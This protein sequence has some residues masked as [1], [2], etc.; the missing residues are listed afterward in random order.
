LETY[1]IS[2]LLREKIKPLQILTIQWLD[3]TFYYTLYNHLLYY[4]VVKKQWLGL[5]RHKK[6]KKEWL[7]SLQKSRDVDYIE[8]QFL[9]NMD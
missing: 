6:H 9:S 5:A 2:L 1:F 4:K 3:P 7:D 8:N